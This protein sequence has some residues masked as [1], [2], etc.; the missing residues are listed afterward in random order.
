[1]L[2]LSLFISLSL[3]TA[4]ASAR[5]LTERDGTVDVRDFA[6]LRSQPKQS[7]IAQPQSGNDLGSI[8]G[9]WI[10][11]QTNLIT[12]GAEQKLLEDMNRGLSK[13]MTRIIASYAPTTPVEVTAP[14]KQSS[15][16][17]L[18]PMRFTHVNRMQMDLS[19]D[20]NLSCFW[21]GDSFEWDLSRRLDRNFDLKLRH[22]SRDAKSSVLINYDW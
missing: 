10:M 17:D 12:G 15:A 4:N 6:P 20:T 22:Q 5:V 3:I 14:Q 8:G 1:M 16:E 11:R 18:Q 13:G 19:L 21:K 9:D 2:P 7:F